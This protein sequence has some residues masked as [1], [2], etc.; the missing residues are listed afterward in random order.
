MNSLARKIIVVLFAVILGI[1]L[2]TPQAD[3]VDH[4]KG[5]LCFHCNRMVPQ[6][7]QLIPT[8]GFGGQICDSSFATS[9]CNLN[10]YQ[11]SNTKIFIVTTIKQSRQKTGCSITF[12]VFGTSLV[13]NAIGNGNRG[14]FRMTSDTIPLYLQNLSLLC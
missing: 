4:C 9:P 14:Q 12:A 2:I 13:Q 11:D 10:N 8:I 5:S 6:S 1:S 3:A 7:N